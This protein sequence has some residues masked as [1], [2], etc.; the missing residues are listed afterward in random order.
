MISSVKGSAAAVSLNNAVTER[1][2]ESRESCSSCK[3]QLRKT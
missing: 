1:I 3:E 2:S